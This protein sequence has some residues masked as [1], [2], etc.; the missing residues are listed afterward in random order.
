[1]ET[2]PEHRPVRRLLAL[3]PAA[4]D[5]LFLGLFVLAS[6]LLYAGR[7]GFYS[8][9]W[10]YLSRLCNCR[11]QSMAGLFACMGWPGLYIRPLQLVQLAV[12]YK[13]SGLDPLLYHVMNTLVFAVAVLLFHHAL[14]KLRAPD[15]VAL[16]APLLWASVPLFSTDR[17]WI[18]V[19]MANLS[20]VFCFGAFLFLG[21]SATGTSLRAVC[22]RLGCLVAMGASALSY[23]APVGLFAMVP[24][25]SWYAGPTPEKSAKWRWLRTHRGFALISGLL[26]V[27]GVILKLVSQQRQVF[28]GRF[29]KHMDKVALHAISQGLEFNFGRL[30]LGVPA[31]AWQSLR[32]YSDAAR[33]GVAVVLGIAVFAYLYL[34]FRDDAGV[35]SSWM[36]FPATAL[37]GLV[38]Y[39]LGYVLFGAMIHDEFANTGVWNRVAIASASGAA[40]AMVGM[41][42]CMAWAFRRPRFQR[43][44]FAFLIAVVAASG[45]LAVN[46]LAGLW[47]EARHRQQVVL[48]DIRSRHATLPLG[49]TFILSGVCPYVGP[50]IVFECDW[51]LA[52]ALQILYRD[53]T[54]KADVATPALKTEAAGLS[55]LFYEVE[56]TYPYGPNL[57]LY[58]F[59]T[60]ALVRLT[61]EPTARRYLGPGGSA[62]LPQCPPGREGYGTA[63][64]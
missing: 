59:R 42:G 38:I 19:F 9:D 12:L 44:A 31:A 13:L 56:T 1:M 39:S 10:E 18:A 43:A 37:A 14:R 21:A 6:C 47:I 24:V 58:D 11:D 32:Q 27:S 57:L 16:C 30:G 2:A 55:K 60:K 61:D 22:L 40:I 52:G 23:E 53:P 3:R 51:D 35:S 26:L 48:D 20:M 50:G 4:S 25:L 54:L 46:T 29:L 63:V 5:S 64:F 17:F 33:L 7:L 45:V 49:S 62:A 41:L 34:R 28:Q 36:M 15:I 8:D